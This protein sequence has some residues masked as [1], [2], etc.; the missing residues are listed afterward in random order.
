MTYIRRSTLATAALTLVLT[1]APAGAFH[2]GSGAGLPQPTLLRLTGFVGSAPHGVTT[3]GAVTLGLD[4]T[5]ATL[6]LEGVQILNGSLTEGRSA[7]RAFDLYS[8]NLLLVGRRDVLR[9]ISGAAEHS[10]VTLIGYIIP[11]AQRLL[12]VEVDPG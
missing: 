11:G 4:H 6:D 8:P 3:I 12:V 2:F 9:D 7:L 5:V 1:A 10:K